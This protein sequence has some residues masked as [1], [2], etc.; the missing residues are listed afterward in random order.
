MKVHKSSAVGKTEMAARD[1]IRAMLD[2]AVVQ[3]RLAQKPPRGP[4]RIKLLTLAVRGTF[5]RK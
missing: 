2:E 1:A 3:H 5:G 4:S